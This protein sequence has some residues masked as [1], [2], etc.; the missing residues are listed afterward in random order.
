MYEDECWYCE[1]RAAH[2]PTSAVTVFGT[3]TIRLADGG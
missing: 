3:H 1:P 2:C